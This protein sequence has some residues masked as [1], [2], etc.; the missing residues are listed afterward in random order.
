MG[1]F[2]PDS[3]SAL[4]AI[5]PA[6]QELGEPLEHFATLA[7]WNGI[8]DLVHFGGLGSYEDGAKLTGGTDSVRLHRAAG[9]TLQHVARVW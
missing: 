9:I 6:A 8:P 3:W 1:R 7:L 2:C 5:K 4:A